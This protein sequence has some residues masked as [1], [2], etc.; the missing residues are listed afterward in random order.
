[1]ELERAVVTTAKYAADPGNPL[2]IRTSA[3][4]VVAMLSAAG[5]TQSPAPEP[6]PQ[7]VADTWVERFAAHD[8]AGIATLYTED[9]QLLPPDMEVVSGRAAIQEFFARTNPPDAPELEFATVETRVFGEYAHRQGTFT[10]KGPDGQV[11]VTGKFIELWRKIDGKWLIHR[12]MWSWN[13]AAP[14]VTDAP[15]D[16]P[17]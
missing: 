11:V 7:D 17:A 10:A 1:V 3:M 12:D 15:P 4:I 9:A 16:E 8:A 2:M 13:A 6:F 14:P 5:C